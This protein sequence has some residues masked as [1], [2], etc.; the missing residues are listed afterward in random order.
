MGSDQEIGTDVYQQKDDVKGLAGVLGPVLLI[1][2]VQWDMYSCL[3]LGS[4]TPDT[5]V[6]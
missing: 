1:L 4:S 3:P 5:H 6:R 2:V